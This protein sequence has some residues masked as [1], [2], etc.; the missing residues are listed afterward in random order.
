MALPENPARIETAACLNLEGCLSLIEAIVRDA[1]ND[2]ICA[3]REYRKTPYDKGAKHHYQ[4]CRRF[5]LSEYFF[6]LAKLDGKAI[7]IKLDAQA[8]GERY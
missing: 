7:L 5:F 8:G 6:T 4:V 2:Y 3:R 1:A